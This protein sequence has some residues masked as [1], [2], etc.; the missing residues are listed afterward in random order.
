MDA[1]FPKKLEKY[2]AC[3]KCQPKKRDGIEILPWQSVM[4][5]IFSDKKPGI[6]RKRAD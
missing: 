4:R 2:V 5:R 6:E 3:L 1:Y